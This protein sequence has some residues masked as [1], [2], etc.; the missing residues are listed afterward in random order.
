MRCSVCDEEILPSD[1]LDECEGY[2]AHTEC[3]SGVPFARRQKEDI[4]LDEWDDDPQGV[5][6]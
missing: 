1:A 6:V 3:R 2:P 4:L 5:P